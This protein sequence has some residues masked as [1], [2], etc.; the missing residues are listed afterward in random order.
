MDTYLI[1]GGDLILDIIVTEV[2]ETK[3]GESSL[4]SVSF[5]FYL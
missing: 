1:E 3:G 2:R 5:A 4:G